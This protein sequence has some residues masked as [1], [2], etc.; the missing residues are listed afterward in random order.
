MLPATRMVS[1]SPMPA[2]KIISGEITDWREVG[3][4]PGAI[5][6]HIARQGTGLAEMQSAILNTPSTA[7]GSVKHGNSNEIGAAVAADKQAAF[8][9]TQGARS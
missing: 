4:K 3:G 6:L 1:R 8:Q 7:R 5:R 9:A 2:S